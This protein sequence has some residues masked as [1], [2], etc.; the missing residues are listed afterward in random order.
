[1]SK[2]LNGLSAFLAV[3]STALFVVSSI[4]YADDRAG[5]KS[6]SWIVIRED[7]I[8]YFGLRKAFFDFSSTGT[9]TII[10]YKSQADCPDDW[11][12]TCNVAGESAFPLM[13]VSLIL[14]F[15]VVLSNGVLLIAPNF[16]VQL[17]NIAMSF[18]SALF[19]LIAI[20]YFMSVCYESIELSTD[21]T[22]TTDREQR[23]GSGSI[24]AIV[25]ML[26]MWFVVLF[27][28]GAAVLAP[29]SLH[30]EIDNDMI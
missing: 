6:A 23:W 21:I 25:G 3:T 16:Y 9:D 27:Q 11:C 15:V 12:D 24:T 19:S 30:N 22:P 18:V 5:L 4:G 7:G 2:I 17:T 13:L 20:G 10:T 14:S 8:A 26:L 28:A 29:K 1:M